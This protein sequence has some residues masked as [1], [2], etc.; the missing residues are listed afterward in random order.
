MDLMDGG[1]APPTAPQPQQQS[2]KIQF[3]G[4]GAAGA[5]VCLLPEN[6]KRCRRTPHVKIVPDELKRP[7]TRQLY[8]E[9]AWQRA[10]AHPTVRKRRLNWPTLALACG[11]V[12][13]RR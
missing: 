13:H 5:A 7:G 10:R 9:R 6:V 1:I 11:L 12:F 8:R 3:K 4:E 2:K